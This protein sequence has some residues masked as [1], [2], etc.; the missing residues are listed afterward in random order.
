MALIPPFTASIYKTAQKGKLR[1][2]FFEHNKISAFFTN[3]EQ[4]G[5]QF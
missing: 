4:I 5:V 3:K 1:Q 2:N